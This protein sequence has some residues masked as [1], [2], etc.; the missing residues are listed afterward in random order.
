MPPYFL[1][2]YW[3]L[4]CQWKTWTLLKKDK[5]LKS[6]LLE[7]YRPFAE[8]P[9]KE[10]FP[11]TIPFVLNGERYFMHAYWLRSISKAYKVYAGSRLIKRA[12]INAPEISLVLVHKVVQRICVVQFQKS[13]NADR[14]QH[15]SEVMGIQLAEELKKWHRMAGADLW[16]LKSLCNGHDANWISRKIREIQFS[17]FLECL[18]AFSQD[19]TDSACSFLKQSELVGPFAI[20]HGD[21]HRGN[22]LRNSQGEFVWLDLDAMAYQPIFQ[23]LA[24]LQ[25]IFLF[26]YPKA[27]VSLEMRYFENDSQ[28]YELWK[29][30]RLHWYVIQGAYHAAQLLR[31]G[32]CLPGHKPVILKHKDRSLRTANQAFQKAKL[33][34]RLLEKDATPNNLQIQD[35]LLYLQNG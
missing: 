26:R 14:I 10:S 12:K 18:D 1:I 21:I 32:S 16:S 19:V 5:N 23:E 34:L 35:I 15:W 30:F 31:V 17:P 27:A 20:C 33:A 11:K 22:L 24:W 13:V 25:F 28:L 7:V 8:Q 9:E 4:E 2:I 29:Q 3:F 6:K